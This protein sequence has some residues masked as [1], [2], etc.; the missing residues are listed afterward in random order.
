MAMTLIQS[1]VLSASAASVTFSSI[2]QTFKTLHVVVSGRSSYASIGASLIM[3]VNG[4]STAIYSLRRLRGNG[5]VANSYAE[6]GSTYLTQY[7]IT[8]GANVTANTFSN[9]SFSIPNYTSSALKVL[10]MDSVGENNATEAYQDFTAGLISTTAAITSITLST[11]T[12]F[13]ANS[14]FYL[15]GI[16]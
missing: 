16:K 11:E 9:A 13:V 4:L 14:T 3:Q 15:Y 12:S 1:Q 6:S 10:S 8:P 2:P 5:S 7:A